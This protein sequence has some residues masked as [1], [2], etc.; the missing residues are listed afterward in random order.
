MVD[1]PSI[2]DQE[3]ELR[4]HI[5]PVPNYVI[6]EKRD[7]AQMSDIGARALSESTRN[8]FAIPAREATK[9]AEQ[10]TLQEREATKR[11]YATTVVVGGISLGVLVLILVG[12]GNGQ[13]VDM[14]LLASLLGLG[15]LAMGGPTLQKLADKWIEKT[16]PAITGESPP[17]LP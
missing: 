9:Q 4:R 5:V 15:L 7:F 16:F 3:Q 1:D 2:E 6:V 11:F 10:K 12:M 8:Q 14:R 13:G 17:P